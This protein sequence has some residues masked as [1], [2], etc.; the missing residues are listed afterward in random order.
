MI[1]NAII[2]LKYIINKLTYATN[3]ITYSLSHQ[4]PL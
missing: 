2:K 3:V 4:P 1:L